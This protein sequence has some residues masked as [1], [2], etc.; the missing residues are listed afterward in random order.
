[1]N[2]QRNATQGEISI[3]IFVIC[4]STSALHTIV[5]HSMALIIVLRIDLTTICFPTQPQWAKRDS[6][7]GFGHRLLMEHVNTKRQGKLTSQHLRQAL[8]HKEVGT[9]HDKRISF[10]HLIQSHLELP[11]SFCRFAVEFYM[12]RV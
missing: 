10:S 12:V 8:L 2:V 3:Y 5:D 7:V 9:G 11:T 4:C 6:K 1:M